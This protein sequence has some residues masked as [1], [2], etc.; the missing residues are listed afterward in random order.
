M[1]KEERIFG[2]NKQSCPS[3]IVKRGVREGGGRLRG[4]DGEALREK[5]GET[6]K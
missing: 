5:I 4:R 2:G 6:R 1:T 3:I